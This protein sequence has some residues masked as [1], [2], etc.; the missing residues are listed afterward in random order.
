MKEREFREITPEDVGR[1]VFSAFGRQWRVSEFIGQI[2]D[3]DVG[4]RVYRA[5]EHVVSVENAEQFKARMAAKARTDSNTE[6]MANLVYRL[7]SSLTDTQRTLSG[8]DLVRPPNPA[9]GHAVAVLFAD[10]K[11]VVV[12]FEESGGR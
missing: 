10:G 1:S 6:R 8:I 9:H 4:K 3:V 12:R 5:S 11:D 7:L 2:F